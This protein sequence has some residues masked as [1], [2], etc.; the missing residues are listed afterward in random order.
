MA[1]VF[2]GAFSAGLG[3]GAGF[4]RSLAARSE[5]RREGR[6]GSFAPSLSLRREPLR[7]WRSRS[8]ASASMRETFPL[9]AAGFAAAGGASGAVAGA[10]VSAA[11]SSA[12]R[13]APMAEAAAGRAA[14]MSLYSAKISSTDMAPNSTSSSLISLGCAGSTGRASR[15]V[16]RGAGAG[17]GAASGAWFEGASAAGRR[18]K[19]NRA[20]GSAG[21]TGAG[22]AGRGS[23]G[24]ASKVWI[25]GASCAGRSFPS[26]RRFFRGSRLREARR[27]SCFF[28][29]PA[30][31]RRGEGVRSASPR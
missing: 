15:A 13:S 18:R 27:A 16:R 10:S 21:S 26:P 31:L 29:S 3:A 9:G 19:P 30:A 22:G 17:F 23:C 28:S 7:I 4:A 20:A 2:S 1:A 8:C 5:R 11:A 14:N 24:G 6:L 12:A 25:G